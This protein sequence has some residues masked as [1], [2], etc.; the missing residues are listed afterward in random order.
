[1]IIPQR[2][3]LICIYVISAL[4]TNIPNMAFAESAKLSMIPT[5]IVVAELT[6]AEAQAKVQSLLSRS[7]VQKQ[8]LANGVSIEEAS[9]RVASLSEAELRNLAGQLEQ[10]RAGGDVLVAVLLVVL[11]IY[12][13]KRI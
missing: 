9:R 7:E 2:L 12:L 13:V 1:M 10:E 3:K 6:R 4:L 5:S 11:I 8:L